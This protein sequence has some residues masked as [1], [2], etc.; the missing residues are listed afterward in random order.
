M[1]NCITLKNLDLCKNSIL[2]LLALQI[3]GNREGILQD[4]FKASNF[5][6]SA[7]TVVKNIE[8]PN[9]LIAE[10]GL[11]KIDLVDGAD[12]FVI[13]Y[14]ANF[15]LFFIVNI[16]LIHKE[17][18]YMPFIKTCINNCKTSRSFLYI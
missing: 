14:L 13:G 8:V 18:V 4:D 15:P 10:K 9:L 11:S 5:S 1:D 12:P 2:Y 7:G 6:S 16:I 17:L 3:P